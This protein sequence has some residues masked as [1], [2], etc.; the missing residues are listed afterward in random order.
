[1]P[2]LL[3]PAVR[4]DRRV[5]PAGRPAGGIA[6]YGIGAVLALMAMFGGIAALALGRHE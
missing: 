5:L 1:M 4:R 2:D 6:A 3:E